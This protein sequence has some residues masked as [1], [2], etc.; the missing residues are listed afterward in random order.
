VASL[1]RPP[2]LRSQPLPRPFRPHARQGCLA[3]SVFRPHARVV[4][5][6][7]A[8]FRPPC[9]S[10]HTASLPRPPTSCAQHTALLPRCLGH[11]ASP[12]ANM[13]PRCLRPPAPQRANTPGPRPLGLVRSQQALA[14]S[15]HFRPHAQ[16]AAPALLG[17]PRGAATACLLPSARRPPCAA[18]ATSLPRPFRPHAPSQPLPRPLSASSPASCPR[19]LGHFRPHARQATRCLGGSATCAPTAAPRCL[20]PRGLMRQPTASL[21]GSAS[22]CPANRCLAASLPQ[23]LGLMRSQHAASL[24]RPL[25]APRALTL[26]ATSAHSACVRSQQ[27]ASLPRPTRP[28]APAST[29]A[30]LP[31]PRGPAPSLRCLRCPRPLSAS[32]A[33]RQATLLPRPS[34]PRDLGHFRPHAQQATWPRPPASCAFQQAACARRAVAPPALCSSALRLYAIPRPHLR[35]CS[36]CVVLLGPRLYAIPRPHLRGCSACVVLLGSSAL[37]HPETTPARLLRPR[38]APRLL[39]STPSRDHTCAVAP[40]ALCSSALDSRHPRPHLRGCSACVVLLG[41]RLSPSRETTLRD[42]ALAAS[43]PARV[44][45]LGSSALRHPRPH[46]RGHPACVV[47]LG[48][49]LYAIPRDH[50][51]G[52]PLR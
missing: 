32:C 18:S 22:S 21:A 37:R 16:P 41:P 34:A 8:T 46:L 17:P 43:Q 27:A 4:T 33:S 40:P 48:P 3:A 13:L 31:R 50:L 49:R 47:L 42:H 35:G 19:C 52:H 6:A 51:R 23:P 12:R 20:G 28:H 2:A 39:G 29:P 26:A 7:S 10:Q 25:S 15:A 38:R 45:L 11:S 30:W 44:V 14:A 24:P 5:A 9:A 1:P 36:A